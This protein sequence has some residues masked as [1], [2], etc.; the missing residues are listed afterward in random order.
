VLESVGAPGEFFNAASTFSNLVL[1][2]KE[3][4]VLQG[5]VYIPMYVQNGHTIRKGDFGLWNYKP[6]AGG[7]GADPYTFY[8]SIFHH[9]EPCSSSLAS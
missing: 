9:H 6:F 7:G 3:A 4:V 5:L 8:D 1:K 2:R